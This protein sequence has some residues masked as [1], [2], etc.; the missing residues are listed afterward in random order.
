MGA[1][2]LGYIPL[3]TADTLSFQELLQ[4]SLFVSVCYVGTECS[5][6]AFLGHF[7]FIYCVESAWLSVP[8]SFLGEQLIMGHEDQRLTSSSQDSSLRPARAS[9]L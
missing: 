9:A 5:H 1:F 2:G 8:F 4:A 3:G 6:T 7:D